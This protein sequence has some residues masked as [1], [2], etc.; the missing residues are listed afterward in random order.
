MSKESFFNSVLKDSNINFVKGNT[1][2]SN[3][4]PDMMER[5]MDM[6]ELNERIG[7]LYEAYV[8]HASRQKYKYVNILVNYLL[9]IACKMMQKSKTS[10]KPSLSEVCQVSFDNFIE[11]DEKTGMYPHG[12]NI[13]N[14]ITNLSERYLDEAI[15]EEFLGFIDKY[16][17][18]DEE[19]FANAALFSYSGKSATPS[20]VKK[21]ALGILDIQSGD[22]VMDLGC[23]GGGFMSKMFDLNKLARYTEGKYADVFTGGKYY[24]YEISVEEQEV[25]VL[26]AN[27]LGVHNI[28]GNFT[29]VDSDYSDGIC[30]TNKFDK[31]F[32]N[33]PLGL[34]YLPKGLEA[35][36]KSSDWAFNNWICNHLSKGGKAVAIMSNGSVWNTADMAIRKEFIEK[37]LVE[38]VIALPEGLFS[39]TN[40][41]TTMIV[42]SHGNKSVKMV[43]KIDY[44]IMSMLDGYEKKILTGLKSDTEYSKTVSLSELRDN[45][46]VLNYNR[47]ITPTFKFKDCKK[48]G[49]F[50]NSIRRGVSCKE[51]PPETYPVLSLSLSNIKNGLID[52]DLP[53]VF[54]PENAVKSDMYLKENDLIISKSGEPYKIAV[55]SEPQPKPWGREPVVPSGNM[56]V[57]ELDT[58]R[59]N[60]YYVKVFLE[61]QQGKAL[62]NSRSNQATIINISRKELENLDIPV[63]PLDVQNKIAE[64]YLARADEYKV[65][66]AKLEDVTNRMNSVFDDNYEG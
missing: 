18:Y 44:N 13:P 62:L 10:Q 12:Y 38:A 46:Y 31:I 51:V 56:Y 40:I 57:I 34:K 59:I 30:D 1:D 21:I 53:S 6:Y 16:K 24:G 28:G 61:S 37:G 48:L 49:D 20:V 41:A 2:S 42:F 5:R 23:G 3:E 27:L 22:K 4:R 19:F 43:E 58:N 54:Y 65:C 9:F 64:A 15:W 26:R 29:N 17:Q 36:G 50:I 39:D 63:P 35:K 32:A 8:Q 52:E 11:N 14:I 55:F 66:Q 25:A 33:Y 47:Y 45:D 7:A 60:P